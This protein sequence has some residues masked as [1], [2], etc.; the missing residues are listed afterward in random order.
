MRSMK[1]TDLFSFESIILTVVLPVGT[2]L[3]CER[4]S[5][6]V[7]SF[8]GTWQSIILF[9]MNWGYSIIQYY[10]IQLKA[11]CRCSPNLYAKI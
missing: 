7:Q 3:N 1:F 10:I 5:C 2:L 6:C 9:V 8:H 11:P 4:S